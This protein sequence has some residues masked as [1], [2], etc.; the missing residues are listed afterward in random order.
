MSFDIEI[1]GCHPLKNRHHKSFKDPPV[2]LKDAASLPQY[3]IFGTFTIIKPTLMH[4]IYFAC[5][6]A[7]TGPHKLLIRTDFFNNLS[8]REETLYEFLITQH[9]N[10]IELPITVCACPAKLLFE[11]GCQCSGIK[12]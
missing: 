9:L 6:M 4:P 10:T 1:L 3:E 11:A 7:I 12:N 5:Y 8:K 2:V